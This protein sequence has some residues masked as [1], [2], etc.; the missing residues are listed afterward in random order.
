MTDVTR[1]NATAPRFT[2]EATDGFARAGELKLPRGAVQTPIFMPVGTLGTVK[3]LDPRD[4]HEL[5]A[6]IILGNTYH[7]YLRPGEE[8]LS[9]FGGLHAFMDW[10]LPILT[11][12]GG[13]QFYS[14][15]HL[16]KF[17]DDGVSFQSHLD[18]SRHRFTPERVMEIQ[19]AIG[20]NIRMVLDECVAL[21][22]ERAQLERAMHRST[23]WALRSL[24]QHPHDGNAVFAII[25][26]GSEPSLRSAH[27]DA[28]CAH[29]FDGFAIGGLSVGEA[30]ETM[31]RV[32]G[33]LAPTMPEDKPRYLMGVG[34]PR[35]L[36]ENI[37]RGVDMFDCVMPT[38]N[39]RTGTV[40]T[41]TGRMNM[42]NARWRFDEAPLDERCTCVAC[43]RFSRAYLSHL[44][45]ANEALAHRMLSI[46]NLHFYLQLVAQARA[47]ILQGELEA[48]AA[49]QLAAWGFEPL[50]L[51]GG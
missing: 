49:E 20:S 47:A 36:V 13:F 22:A 6:Q 10:D 21:P 43:Q 5:G 37:R 7:L 44:Y 3:A 27:R 9:H 19:A 31:Y 28:L 25:Q 26:G 50:P 1:S 39:G 33:G 23:D 41:S 40:F 24:A 48:W 2:V 29:D 14:L 11:D 46:H 42:K 45:R 32:V 4:L 18:G 30:P 17:D 15:N 16:A 35:D 34:T 12:S 8:V 51:D 38:R